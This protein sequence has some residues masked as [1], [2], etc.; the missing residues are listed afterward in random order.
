MWSVAL[1]QVCYDACVSAKLEAMSRAD[2]SQE[3][4]TRVSIESSENIAPLVTPPDPHTPPRPCSTTLTRTD[5]CG[6]CWA[7][8]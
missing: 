3:H 2:I 5:G 6:A 4:M 8:R 7:G 1:P